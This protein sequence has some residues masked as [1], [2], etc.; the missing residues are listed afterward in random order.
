MSKTPEPLAELIPEALSKLTTTRDTAPRQTDWKPDLN[1][2]H[3]SVK[4]AF[5][6]GIRF[7]TEAETNAAKGNLMAGRWLTLTGKPGCG[8]TTLAGQIFDRMKKINP[9]NVPRT[10]SSL[11]ADPPRRPTCVW[12]SEARF[13]ERLRAREYDLPEYLG[14]DYIVCID[15][16]GSARD[17]TDYLADALFRM[18][19]ARLGKWTLFTTNLS[20]PEIAQ[21]IDDRVASRLIR[22]ANDV[23]TIMAG[24]YAMRAR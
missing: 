17:R 11:R 6:A 7:V 12:M 18:C 10:F 22:D 3:P 23:V 24:D 1:P 21:R 14:E 8:K 20:L 4:S 2:W 13:A 15:D 9:H 19:S 5:A 16:L